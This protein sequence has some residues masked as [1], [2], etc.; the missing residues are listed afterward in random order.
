MRQGAN[1]WALPEGEAE[2][3]ILAKAYPF[4]APSVSYVFRDGTASGIEGA[5]FDGRVPVI[6]HGSN[7]SPEQLKRKFDR[8][9]GAAG[10]IPVTLGWLDGY[11][12]VYSAHI[13]TYGSVASTLQHVPGCR[14]RVAITW[15]NDAQVARMHETEGNNYSYG[16]LEEVTIDLE[17]GPS[18][19]LSQAFLYMSA[20]GCLAVEG[21]PVGLA[22]VASEGRRHESLS[23]EQAI[24]LVRDQYR[25]DIAL[26]AFIL[27]MIRDLDRRRAVI[28]DLRRA[29]APAAA[30][31]FRILEM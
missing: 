18:K 26:D 30:P 25:P 15:L 3:L 23:Q 6:A 11:D 16:L 27:E 31:H 22:G 29:A 10:E 21:G 17:A 12:I 28:Q 1:P 13:T 19:E 7:R 9:S 4:P 2:L 20:N 5:R 14:V 8:L 24:T